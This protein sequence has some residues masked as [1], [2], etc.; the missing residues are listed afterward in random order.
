[1]LTTHFY[2]KLLQKITKTQWN[3]V[4]HLNIKCVLTGIICNFFICFDKFNILKLFNNLYSVVSIRDISSVISTAN[5][6]F[7]ITFDL[8]HDVEE[9]TFLS[10]NQVCFVVAGGHNKTSSILLNYCSVLKVSFF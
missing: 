9:V 8:C 6:T 1:M 4:I 5:I 7:Y 2:H 10:E 3:V